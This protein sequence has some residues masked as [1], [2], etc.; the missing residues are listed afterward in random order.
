MRRQLDSKRT[1][2]NIPTTLIYA[3]NKN[4]WSG[5]PIHI[6]TNERI[7]KPTGNTTETLYTQ[8]RKR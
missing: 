7:G 4:M 5:Y 1:E 8:T 2:L 6:W 3:L